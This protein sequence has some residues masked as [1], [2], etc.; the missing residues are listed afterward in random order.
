MLTVELK[1]K[2]ELDLP[3]D[4]EIDMGLLAS[5]VAEEIAID[6][7]YIDVMDEDTGDDEEQ[8]VGVTIVSV[9][10]IK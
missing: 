4:A 9:E 6:T 1:I 3:G 2:M 8:E 10:P 7:L 5:S